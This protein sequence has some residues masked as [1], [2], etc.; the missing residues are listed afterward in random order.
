MTDAEIQQAY[1]RRRREMEEASYSH[2]EGHS[3]HVILKVLARQ[4]A[5]LDDPSKVSSHDTVRDLA[6]LAMGELASRYG[7]KP[8]F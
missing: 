7:I 3:T 4:L 1:R 2:P 8:V 6:G 5:Q